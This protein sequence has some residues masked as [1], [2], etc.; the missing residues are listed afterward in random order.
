MGGG[1][2]GWGQSVRSRGAGSEQGSRSQSR[3][4][5]SLR[6]TR[7]LANLEASSA[8]VCGVRASPAPRR[9]ASSCITRAAAAGAK[10]RD[11]E[12]D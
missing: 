2:P 12:G 5:R 9:G 11:T 6:G 10:S 4:T 8:S 7:V 1:R 3:A